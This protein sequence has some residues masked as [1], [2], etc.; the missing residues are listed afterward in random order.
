MTSQLDNELKNFHFQ[1]IEWVISFPHRG[2]EN[3]K[4]LFYSVQFWDR[5]NG[6][7]STVCLTEKV[8]TPEFEAHFPHT[9]GFFK[10]QINDKTDLKSSYLEIRMVNSIEEFWKFLNDLNI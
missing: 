8:D 6:S 5:K 2:N 4:Y 1:E 3:R 10:G 7:A 9:V